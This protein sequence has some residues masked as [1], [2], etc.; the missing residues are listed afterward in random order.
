M[1]KIVNRFSANAALDPPTIVRAA[2]LLVERDG[3]QALTMR[4]LGSELGVEAMSIYHHIPNKAALLELLAAAA[5]RVPERTPGDA[6]GDAV[7]EL[8]RAARRLHGSLDARRELVPLV[9]ASP[10]R[11]QL[12]SIF[13]DARRLL[14]DAGFDPQAVAWITDSISD[15]VLGSAALEGSDSNARSKATFET[16]L[17]LLLLGVRAELGE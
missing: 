3:L 4:R 2:L 5:C 13:A 8:D 14:A 7:A 6:D 11:E 9:I 12:D 15:Y 10:P 16:G 17:R 1:T